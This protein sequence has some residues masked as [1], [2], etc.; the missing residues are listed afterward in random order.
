MDNI[1]NEEATVI[2]EV[3]EQLRDALR[4]DEPHYREVFDQYVELR[5]QCGESTSE[6]SFDKFVLTL[7]KNRDQILMTRPEVKQV[8]FTVYVKAGKAALK[9]TPSKG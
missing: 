7:R 8:R 5:R 3:S 4:E 6:L 1:G 9:A 2:A